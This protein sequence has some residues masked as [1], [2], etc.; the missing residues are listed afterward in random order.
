MLPLLLGSF[1]CRAVITASGRNRFAGSKQQLPKVVA[2]AFLSVS[3]AKRS[4]PLAVA[5]AFLSVDRAKRSLPL[6]VIAFDG[7]N[8]NTNFKTTCCDDLFISALLNVLLL[9]RSKR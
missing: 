6:A 7:H 3:C 8:R 9:F 2:N 4:L 5:T 1:A